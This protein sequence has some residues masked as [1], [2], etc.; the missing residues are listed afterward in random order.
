MNSL[1]SVGAC[2]FLLASVLMNAGPARA[3]QSVSEK[4]RNNHAA[5]TRFLDLQKMT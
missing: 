3:A 2:V 5:A 4:M 1:K